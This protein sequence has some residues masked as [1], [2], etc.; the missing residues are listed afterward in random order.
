MQYIS[1]FSFGGAYYVPRHIM[2][3]IKYCCNNNI[4]FGYVK[5]TITIP[6]HT[7][8]K[9]NRINHRITANRCIIE[10]I[11]IIYLTLLLVF[12]YYI[13]FIIILYTITYKYILN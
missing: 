4:F 13:L 3:L 11:A 7:I 2:Y 1:P 12:V 5:Y 6:Y 8:P 9:P 10:N